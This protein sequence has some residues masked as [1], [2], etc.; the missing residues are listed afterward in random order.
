MTEIGTDAV[1]NN[2]TQ[3]E[4]AT[5]SQNMYS[6]TYTVTSDLINSYA[7]DTAMVFAQSFGQNGYSVQTSVNDTLAN[8]GTN[9]ADYIGTI[10]KQCNIYDMASNVREW[11]TEIYS[12]FNSSCTFRG[13]FY[14]YLSSY[15]STHYHESTSSSTSNTGF[16]PILYF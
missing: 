16:R 6:E 3:S 12:N 9:D 14:S 8:K 15:T 7:W 13:G 1:W 2:I 4:A 10:D 11:S 5:K